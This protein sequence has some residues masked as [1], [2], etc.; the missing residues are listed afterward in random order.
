MNSISVIIRTGAEENI[1]RQC[2]EA[3]QA[4]GKEFEIFLI[5]DE[6]QKISEAFREAVDLAVGNHDLLFLR[7]NVVLQKGAVDEMQRFAYAKEKSGLV[8]PIY[9][10]YGRGLESCEEC[11]S[12]DA[13]CVFVRRELWNMVCG[14]SSEYRTDG[15]CICDLAYKLKRAGYQ[16]YLVSHAF[17][18]RYPAYYAGDGEKA[19][20]DVTLFENQ[21]GMDI[22]YYVNPRTD[23]MQLIS[24]SKEQ[25]FHLMEIGCG[26]GATILKIKHQYPNACVQGMELM[27]DVVSLAPETANVICGN[28]ET[29]LLPAEKES[30][31]YIMFGDVLEHLRDTERVLNRM[32]EYLKPE[33]CIITSIP[34]LMHYSVLLPL[35][36]G[37]FEYKDSG[38][39]DRTHLRF[40]TLDS[41]VRMFERC[42]YTI[43]DCRVNEIPPVDSE[44]EQLVNKLAA[45]D[46]RFQMERTKDF[47]YLIRAKKK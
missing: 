42:G 9:E 2:L 11:F 12:P 17:A 38:I 25:Q 6:D 32:K 4:E 43:E 31:D 47:Q 3:L 26:C 8:G 10:N 7:D 18:F 30:L 33:G 28:V 45:V 41:I 19:Y 22:S 35:L 36:M 14:I 46:S 15:F 1:R 23:V 20:D 40:F 37:Q 34:N 44:W 39:L 16:S 24:V 21:F 5:S 29:D 13:D 27:E